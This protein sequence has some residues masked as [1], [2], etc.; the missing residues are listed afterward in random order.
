MY[1]DGFSELRGVLI[2][3]QRW[4]CAFLYNVTGTIGGGDLIFR[5]SYEHGTRIL[6]YSNGCVE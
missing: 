1:I 5:I 6:Q 2:L 4:F 3:F